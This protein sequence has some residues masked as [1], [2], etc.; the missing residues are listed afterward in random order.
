MAGLS[1]YNPSKVR[2]YDEVCLRIHRPSLHWPTSTFKLKEISLNHKLKLD[3]R[4]IQGTYF[5]I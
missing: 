5:A 2:C 4:I 1:I 3:K